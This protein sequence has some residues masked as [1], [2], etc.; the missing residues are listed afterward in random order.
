MPKADLDH[1]KSITAYRKLLLAREAEYRAARPGD[2]R[3]DLISEIIEEIRAEA[4]NTGAK[5]PDDDVL[6]KV[7]GVFRLR[8]Y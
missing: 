5:L 1:T 7:R 3:S 6:H 4:E 2:E 8:C